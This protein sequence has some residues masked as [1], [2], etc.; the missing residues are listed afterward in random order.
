MYRLGC[1][2]KFL[3]SGIKKIKKYHG[4]SRDIL[5]NRFDWFEYTKKIEALQNL[6]LPQNWRRWSWLCIYNT[7]LGA[8]SWY[9][10]PANIS[11]YCTR[12]SLGEVMGPVPGPDFAGCDP[13]LVFSAPPSIGVPFVSWAGC[14]ADARDFLTCN[15][16]IEKLL[17]IHHKS[18]RLF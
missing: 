15:P 2:A 9:S 12:W 5:P 7:F 8:D 3:M 13:E 16:R 4:A 18:M 10:C 6:L 11:L 14:A 17:N 1:S